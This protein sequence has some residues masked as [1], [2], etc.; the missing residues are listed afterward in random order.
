MI[1]C[2]YSE[3]PFCHKNF[4]RLQLVGTGTSGFEWIYV[5]DFTQQKTGAERDSAW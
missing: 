4:Y 2:L 1:N 3:C 5:A